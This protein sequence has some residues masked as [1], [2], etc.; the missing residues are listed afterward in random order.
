MSYELGVEVGAFV[1]LEERGLEREEA[2][3]P[4]DGRR[5]FRNAVLVPGPHLRTNDV[6]GRYAKQLRVCGELQVQAGVVDC[7]DRVGTPL[8]YGPLHRTLD[9]EEEKY[10]LHDWPEPHD[11]KVGRLVAVL[12]G[13]ELASGQRLFQAFRVQ[14]A[15]FLSG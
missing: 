11:G 3:Q 5:H 2:K 12:V 14:N 8:A 6:D 13:A 4:V 15:R 1:V 7:H 9:A 10:P